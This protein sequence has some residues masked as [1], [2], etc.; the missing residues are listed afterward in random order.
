MAELK[1]DEDE[2]IREEHLTPEDVAALRAK[3]GTPVEGMAAAIT[4]NVREEMLRTLRIFCL[5]AI[6]DNPQLWAYYADS[7]RGVC[8]HFK[9]EPGSLFGLAR[10]VDYEATLPPVLVPLRYNP[11][12]QRG[13]AT[14]EPHQARRLE[15]RSG[16]PNSCQPRG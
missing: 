13:R 3:H 5:S 10:A 16:I 7:H 4:K 12:E 11:D 1:K 8:L 15:A 6:K 14:N 2:M 9:A